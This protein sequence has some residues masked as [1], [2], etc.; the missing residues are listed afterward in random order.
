MSPELFAAID[1]WA[2]GVIFLSI[3]SARYPFFRA[4]DDMGHL[5]QI[6][7]LLGSEVCIKAAMD[8]GKDCLR[9]S[10]ENAVCASNSYIFPFVQKPVISGAAGEG[11][12]LLQG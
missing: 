1:I 12:A 3:L 8:F 10:C 9:P 11:M 2:A 5:A 6:I 4:E 7:S